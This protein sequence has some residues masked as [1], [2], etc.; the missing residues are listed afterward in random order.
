MKVMRAGLFFAVCWL[1]LWND[2][3]AQSTAVTFQFTAVITEIKDD[4]NLLQGQVFV[5]E[6]LT[7]SYVFLTGATNQSTIPKVGI[8]EFHDG[9]SCTVNAGSVNFGSNPDNTYLRLEILKNLA[10]GATTR[11][12]TF[13]IHSYNNLPILG[14]LPV[15][16]ISWQIDDFNNAAAVSTS[17]PQ[18]APDLTKYRSIYGLVM[19]GENP[20]DPAQSY[21][22]RA[23]I[24]S[25]TKQ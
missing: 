7:G 21:L 13:L 20:D 18:G 3:S 12:N 8:Y 9:S 5:G 19:S 17:L 15:D 24:T 14:T 23:R 1:G 16:D 4:N 11:R 2:A 6:N 10:D 22:V 25:I